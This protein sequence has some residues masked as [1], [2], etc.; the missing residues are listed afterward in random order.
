MANRPGTIGKW[1][2]AAMVVLIPSSAMADQSWWNRRWSFRREI[3]VQANSEPFTELKLRDDRQAAAVSVVTFGH[4]KPDGGDLRIVGPDNRPR[5]LMILGIGP[6]D[7][8]RVAFPVSGS[9]T[10]RYYLYYGNPQAAKEEHDWRPTTGLLL[11]TWTYKSGAINTPAAIVETVEQKAGDLVGRTFLPT[12]SVPRNI[13]G[14]QNQTC[15]LYTGYLL[16]RSPGAYRFAIS[17][18]DASVLRID[19]KEVVAW[20][21]RHGWVGDVRHQGTIDLD[22]GVHELKLY[23]VNLSNQG[24]AV[25]AWGP[26]AARYIHVISPN[27]FLPTASTEVGRVEMQGRSFVADFAYRQESFAVVDS[28]EIYL[29]EFQAVAPER[30]RKVEYI[31]DFGDGQTLEGQ[32]VR[33]VYLNQGI[34]DVTLRIRAGLRSAETKAKVYVGPNLADWRAE[35]VSVRDYLAVLSTYDFAKLPMVQAL[36]LMRLYL[37][38]ERPDLAIRTGQAVLQD[39]RLSGLPEVVVRA[40]AG[41][42]SDLLIDYQDSY[43]LAATVYQRAAGAVAA[44]KEMQAE[45]LAEA[46]DILVNNL[47]RDQEAEGLLTDPGVPTSQPAEAL[48]RPL[49]IAWGDLFRY[50]GDRNQAERFYAMAEEKREDAQDMARSGGFSVAVEDFLRRKEYA[51]AEK[52]IRRWQRELPS[53]R[54]G[55]YSC[56][57]LYQVYKARGREDQARR[58]AQIINRIDPMGVYARKMAAA[59]TQDAP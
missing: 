26:P 42:L 30:Q 31:W 37:L 46:V 52:L 58:L 57:L 23:H 49:M 45:L 36:G 10:Q 21:G 32:K 22:A 41:M 3:L 35:P 11:E 7:L 12:I 29:Y 13:L 39:D 28:W 40:W 20:P 1:F 34:F 55:G 47:G 24:G 51:E 6:G 5:P 44:N 15:N 27:D 59:T 33:H 38:V 19:G 53:Q 50:R 54:L 8:A 16:C 17:T 18:N 48:P 4:A 14:P 9:G 43:E 56:Y 2:A 25:A